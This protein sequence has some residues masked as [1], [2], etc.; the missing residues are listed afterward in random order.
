MLWE[1]TFFSA[2]MQTG[3]TAKPLTIFLH[4]C[5][6][7]TESKQAHSTPSTHRF[8]KVFFPHRLQPLLGRNARGFR[9]DALGEHTLLLCRTLSCARVT[10]GTGGSDASGVFGPCRTPRGFIWQTGFVGSEATGR[11][12]PE[13]EK[14]VVDGLLQGIEGLLEVVSRDVHGHLAAPLR[15]RASPLIPKADGSFI[16]PSESFSLNF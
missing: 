9:R 4:F 10:C 5:S 14:G 7:L 8:T 2:N 16:G 6:L 11:L 1:E 12:P 3:R 13:G 15:A